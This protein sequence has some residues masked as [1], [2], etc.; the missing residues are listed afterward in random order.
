MTLSLDALARAV[1]GEVIGASIPGITPVDTA[2]EAASVVSATPARFVTLIVVEPDAVT[3]LLQTPGSD[4]RTRA[5]AGAVLATSVPADPEWKALAERNQRTVLVAGIE[6]PALLPTLRET[7]ADH[8]A[9]EDRLVTLGTKVL[10]QVARR[11]G[12]EAVLNELAHRIDGWAVLLDGL[13]VPISAAGA[14]SLH[15]QDAAAVALQRPVKVRHPGLQLHPVG[16]GQEPK[17]HLVISS[18]DSSASRS[19]DLA[20]HA[21][22]LL[23]LVLRTHDHT[24]TER[25]GRE[26]AV[27]TVLSG[28]VDVAQALLLKWGFRERRLACF[29]ISTRS[30]SADLEPVV[31]RWLDE[32]GCPH[33]LADDQG[34]LLGFIPA[35]FADEIAARVEFLAGKTR[36]PLRCGLS[37]EVGVESLA[38]AAT[39]AREAHASAVAGVRF[40]ARYANLP[41]VEFVLNRLDARE[42][43]QLSALLDGLKNER[44]EHGELTDTL[45]VFLTEQGAWGLAAQRLGVHRQTLAS[46]I[47][48]IEQL[49]GL[50]LTDPDDRVAAWL[51]LRATRAQPN[52]GRL[53]RT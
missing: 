14:G 41:S 3:A 8:R 37:S 29:V 24:V 44:G 51:A 38:R 5:L 6:Q 17:A 18:R 7:L 22:A 32:L 2:L 52:A 16:E 45:R 19:R 25:L 15:I 30:R 43:Q 12:A 20:S 10:T 27:E 49:T 35:E 36:V 42:T 34:R 1:G 39:E 21:A 48:R 31:L 9:A 11:G 47:R 40:T 50:T 46:R 13:G 28:D 53:R 33:L 23:D 4:E 26:L